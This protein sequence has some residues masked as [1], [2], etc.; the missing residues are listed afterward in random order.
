MI[1]GH[2]EDACASLFAGLLT[3]TPVSTPSD[4]R[5]GLIVSAKDLVEKNIE[6]SDLSPEVVARLLGVSP[7]TLHRHFAKTGESMM[8]F[9]RRRRLQKAHDDLLRSGSGRSLSDIAARWHF[10]DASHFIRAF[11]YFYGTTP[12]AYLRNSMG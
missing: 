2:L 10:S 9:T 3:E 7:R 5:Q 12:A 6:D 4:P 11:K 8:A 1:D